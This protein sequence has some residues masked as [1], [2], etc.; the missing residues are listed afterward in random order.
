MFDLIKLVN[1]VFCD[2]KILDLKVDVRVCIEFFL[3]WGVLNDWMLWKDLEMGEWYRGGGLRDLY[4][5]FVYSE[6]EKV[7]ICMV[8]V[9]LV[10]MDFF[11]VNLK[12]EC[13]MLVLIE[14]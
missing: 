8:C 5:E 2:W 6:K 1:V 11:L 7:I 14:E 10:L 4:F 9:M 12:G 13:D 3:Y